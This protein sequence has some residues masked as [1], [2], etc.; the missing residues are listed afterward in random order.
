VT[1]TNP[2]NGGTVSGS[3]T[4]SIDAMDPEDETLTSDIYIDDTYI[5]SANS[6][7]CDTTSYADGDHIINTVAT[8]GGGLTDSDI[9]NVPVNNGGNP[10]NSYALVTGISDYRGRRNDLQ[11]CDLDADDWK[12]FPEDKGYTVT[13][14]KDS[15]ANANNIAAEVDNLLALEDGNDHVVLTYSGHGSRISGDGSSIITTDMYYITHGW[16][17]SKFNNADSAHIYFTLDACEIGD[18]QGLITSNRVGAFA[19]NYESS[20]DGDSWMQNG[21]FT[22]YQMEGW[23][24]NDNFEDDGT[25]AV[26]NYESWANAKGWANDAFIDDNYSGSMMP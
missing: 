16:F 12:N 4:I 2:N 21:A 8:D 24:S 19:S 23:N 13:I 17:E 18:F 14:L 15:N 25:Y 20:Y 6:Y 5:T 11:Y 22:Y 1:I 10:V 3:V 26:N 7:S 9:I